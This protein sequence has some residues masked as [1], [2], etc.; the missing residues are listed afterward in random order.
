LYTPE[1]LQELF[2]LKKPDLKASE[3]DSEWRTAAFKAAFQQ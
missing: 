3:G 2:F 1:I